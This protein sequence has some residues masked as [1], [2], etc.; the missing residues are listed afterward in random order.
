M[1]TL[2]HKVLN[3]V[4]GKGRGWVFSP[5]AFLDLG[6]RAAVDQVLHRLADKGSIRRLRRGLYDFPK[7]NPLLGKLT[8]APDR[9]ANALAKNS[10]SRIQVAGAY[11]ANILGLSTQVPGRIVYLT[12]GNSKH[13]QIGNQTIELRHASPK[14][15]AGVGKTSG[16]VIQA[17]RYIGCD[18]VD[19][20]VIARLRSALSDD[21]KAALSKDIAHAP[22]WLRP[23]VY[24]IV[25]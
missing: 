3:R 21:D 15:L 13:V 9:I 19:D 20:K 10:D 23:V 24:Q 11:A 1:Q 7:T 4:R 8:P 12:D 17:L 16:T 18:Q 2:R 5:K 22:D 25:H 14:N 6:S